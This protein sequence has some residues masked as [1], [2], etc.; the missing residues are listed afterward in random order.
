MFPPHVIFVLCPS[1]LVNAN[2]VVYNKSHFNS[3]NWFWEINMNGARGSGL[4]Q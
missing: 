1:I 4:G 3:F 2:Y